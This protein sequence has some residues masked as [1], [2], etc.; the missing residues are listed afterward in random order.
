MYV[1]GSISVHD[2]SEQSEPV[3][4]YTKQGCPDCEIRVDYVFQR[5]RG[6]YINNTHQVHEINESIVP[7]YV[8]K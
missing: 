5:N 6:I 1:F 8:I 7:L 2:A 3:V 4:H